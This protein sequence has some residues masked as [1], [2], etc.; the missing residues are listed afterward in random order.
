L[1]TLSIYGQYHSYKSQ[2]PITQIDLRNNLFSILGRY[3]LPAIRNHGAPQLEESRF[4][5]WYDSSEVD[6]RELIIECRNLGHQIVHIIVG[7]EDEA[8]DFG[9]HK[10]LICHYSPYF[11]AMFTSGFEEAQSGIARLS[12]DTDIETFQLFYDWLYTQVLCNE[13][14]QRPSLTSVIKLYVFADMAR[15]PSLKDQ[16]ID[17]Y[18]AI[19]LETQPPRDHMAKYIWTNT[20]ENDGIRR[21]FVDI[22][23]YEVSPATFKKYEKERNLPIEACFAIMTAM[24]ELLQPNPQESRLYDMSNYYERIL[25][26]PEK[27]PNVSQSVIHWRKIAIQPLQEIEPH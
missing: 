25:P 19:I 11:K 14:E 23:A 20:K 6:T 4:K 22:H 2:L 27:I 1:S 9:V 18:N 16:C 5:Y 13:S 15:V 8:Q 26:L 10:D 21:L 3:Q 7:E 17:A 12:A 24:S